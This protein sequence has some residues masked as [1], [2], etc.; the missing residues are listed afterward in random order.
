MVIEEYQ[1]EIRMIMKQQPWKDLGEEDTEKI[2][3][4]QQVMT[5]ARSADSTDV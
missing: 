1:I 2:V 5:L 4:T 3:Q